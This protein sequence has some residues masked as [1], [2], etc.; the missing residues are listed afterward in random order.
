M[1]RWR[2]LSIRIGF[3]ITLSLLLLGCVS[4]T[5]TAR[6]QTRASGDFSRDQVAKKSRRAAKI[7]SDGAYGFTLSEIVRIDSDVRRDYQRGISLLE[8][9]QLEA[10]VEVLES[11]VER[12][13]EVTNPYID[14]GIAYGRLNRHAE[15]EASLSS[16]L[17][18]SPNHPAALNEL[19]IVQRRTGR[20]EA[21]RASYER[22]LSIHPGFRIPVYQRR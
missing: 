18:L 8:S 4:S 20:F 13:P 6:E 11:V 19:G 17:S 16:A 15:A 21:A 3:L 2:S 1:F 12:A 14:L 9:G 22:A 7:E 10:G 5:N